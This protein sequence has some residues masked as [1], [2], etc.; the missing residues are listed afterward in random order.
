MEA[1]SPLVIMSA[2]SFTLTIAVMII[3]SIV[4]R[5][6]ICR[7]PLQEANGILCG[8]TDFRFSCARHYSALGGNIVK[9]VAFCFHMCRL[10]KR[11]C[12]WVFLPALL[13]T[14]K[15]WLFFAV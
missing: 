6:I 13:L 10:C 1:I 7:Q 8:D 4:I 2:I 12:Q 9:H 14:L 3:P 11:S 5:I 15:F